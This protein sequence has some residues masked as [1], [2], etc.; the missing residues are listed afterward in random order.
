MAESKT[1]GS[2]RRHRARLVTTVTE[3]GRIG[4]PGTGPWVLVRPPHIRDEL[5]P[6]DSA[7]SMQMSTLE[8]AGYIEIRRTFAGKRPRTSASLSAAGSEA[9]RQHVAALQRIL[10][11]SQQDAAPASA[12]PVL[13]PPGSACQR[14]PPVARTAPMGVVSLSG[15]PLIGYER[16]TGVLGAHISPPALLRDRGETR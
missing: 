9:F 6:S 5:G 12:E 3:N 10:A 2:Y 13:A 8:S 7:L 4:L 16:W 15:H 1:I 14:G 11:R